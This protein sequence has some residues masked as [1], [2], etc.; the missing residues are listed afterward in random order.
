MCRR[1]VARLWDWRALVCGAGQKA[2]CGVETTVEHKR[3]KE[4]EQG[5]MENRKMDGRRLRKRGTATQFQEA[6]GTHLDAVE[7]E[8]KRI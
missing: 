2:A 3:R 6:T 1:E 5:G 4:Q 7:H 8:P